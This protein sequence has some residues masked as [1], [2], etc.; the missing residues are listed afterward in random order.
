METKNNILLEL[1]IS[2][3]ILEVAECYNDV[4]QSD[5]Q[6]IAEIKAKNIID[7]L[8]TFWGVV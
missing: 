7:K 5:L 4:T 1:E 8:K 6:A 2:D 3:Y